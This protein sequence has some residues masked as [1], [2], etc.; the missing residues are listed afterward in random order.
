[1]SEQLARYGLEM[2]QAK[3]KLIWIFRSRKFGRA[4]LFLGAISYS[5]YLIHIPVGGRVINLGQRFGDGDLFDLAL[6]LAGTIVSVVFATL[7]WRFFEVPALG[8]SRRIKLT[9]TSHAP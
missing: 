5:L 2:N 4:A 8:L 7:F 3:T 9:K 1:L 6:V